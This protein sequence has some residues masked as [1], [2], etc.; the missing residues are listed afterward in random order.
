MWMY[1]NRYT[2]SRDKLPVLDHFRFRHTPFYYL[3][4][5]WKE[6]TSLFSRYLLIVVLVIYSLLKMAAKKG[7]CRKRK[8]S[9]N[10]SLSLLRCLT[11]WHY[12]AL[13]IYCYFVPSSC[14]EYC[15]ELVCLCMYLCVSV[16]VL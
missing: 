14:E 11:T 4:V 6:I 10:G 16:R 8:W 2:M 15:D 7:A 5:D 13:K 9:K 1:L 12:V 3:K